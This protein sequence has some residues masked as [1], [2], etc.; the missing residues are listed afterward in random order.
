MRKEEVIAEVYELFRTRGGESYGE[1][2]TQRQHAVQV[3][4]LAIGNHESAEG[5]AAAFLHDIA[6]LLTEPGKSGPFGSPNH[7]ALG[8]RW[9]RERGFS[10]TTAC[11][12]EN[13]VAAKRYLTA[14]EEGYFA[15]LSFAS[16]K[17]LVEQGGP[18]S[19]EEARAFEE[20]PLFSR[21]LQLRRWDEAGKDDSADL[22]DV[23]QFRPYLARALGARA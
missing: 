23:E 22:E 2:V 18:M 20:D 3:G 17:T 12:I 6:H 11:L 5:V 19:E 4:L 16:R 1:E 15:R 9:A 8:G 10:E 13:H 7:D 21:H 14:R